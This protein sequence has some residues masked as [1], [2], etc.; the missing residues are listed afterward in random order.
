MDFAKFVAMLK[1]GGLYFPSADQLEDRF[2]GAV[3]LARREHY[4]NSHY[5]DFFRSAVITAPP[6]YPQ[7]NLSDDRIET[8][9]QRLLKEFKAASSRVRSLLV[10]CWYASEVEAEALW[11]LYCPPPTPGLAIRTTVGC[12]WD[13]TAQDA[14]AVVGRVHYVDFRRSFATH[15]KERIFCK[16]LSLSHEREVRVKLDNDHQKPVLGKTVA[17][18][19]NA[20]IEEVIISPFA[21][22][23]FADVVSE[24][25]GKF[26][27]KL[28]VRSSELLDEPFY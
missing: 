8:K 18:D 11:R 28:K 13:A 4:W 24:V 5:L 25:I 26:G 17:C 23:W 7:P 10:S 14:S 21:S 27:Y 19:L 12:L 3:G 6:G 15:D 9:A 1:Q 2:E 22:V 16:R 20:L